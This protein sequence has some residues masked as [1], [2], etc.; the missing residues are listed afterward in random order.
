M[1]QLHSALA[2]DLEHEV[3]V[4]YEPVWAI[5]A[6]KPAEPEHV[7]EVCSALRKHTANRPGRTRLLYGGSAG[8]GTFAD[9]GGSVDG[10]FLGRF[11]HKLANVATV[12]DEVEFH[13]RCGTR[14]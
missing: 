7:Q 1:E 8:P 14:D 12:L 6:S 4:A 11:A 2:G 5:G 10:L 9:L 3:V 13:S